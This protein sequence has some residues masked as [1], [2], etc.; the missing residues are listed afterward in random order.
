MGLGYLILPGIIAGAIPHFG[1]AYK[2]GQL[3]LSTP[4]GLASIIIT[5][6]IWMGSGPMWR[7]TLCIFVAAIVYGLL[8]G[9]K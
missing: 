9:T 5:S 2:H 7:K 8:H 4:L 3:Q 6:L 1:A